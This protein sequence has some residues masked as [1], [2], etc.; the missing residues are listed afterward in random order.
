ME[1]TKQ[2]WSYAFPFPPLPTECI[3]VK[4]FRIRTSAATASPS[5][6]GCTRSS[7]LVLRGT[8]PAHTENRYSSDPS[9]ARMRQQTHPP[10]SP[11]P[12][13]PANIPPS[14]CSSELVGISSRCNVKANGCTWASE[15]LRLQ[16]SGA[17]H[18][19]EIAPNDSAIVEQGRQNE[20]L[21]VDEQHK[22]T[23]T[24]RSHRVRH[25]GWLLSVP[26]NICG[27][28]VTRRVIGIGTLESA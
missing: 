26:R 16:E 10:L 18:R 15:R 23:S 5:H 17:D 19:T 28:R 14:E 20:V 7:S 8:T 12:L 3:H 6:P 9:F 21:V 22:R 25:V 13:P 4:F 27:S 11:S 2:R 1:G 24:R